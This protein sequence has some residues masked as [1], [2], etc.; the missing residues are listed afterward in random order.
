MAKI[1]GKDPGDFVMIEEGQHTFRVKTA[2]VNRPQDGKQ[3]YLYLV[4]SKVE[5]GELEGARH[6]ESFFTH[7]TFGDGLDGAR[8]LLKFLNCCGAL[9]DTE[10][11]SDRFE[12]EKFAVKFE[13]SVPD[14]VYIAE[15]KHKVDKKTGATWPRSVKYANPKV[16]KG[17]GSVSAPSTK[18]EDE[19]W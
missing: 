12:S 17:G 19:D 1:S 9:E 5:G 2:R 7:S 4:E 11:D 18:K 6:F 8:A 16:E 10:F 3:G 14:R 13:K 15:I